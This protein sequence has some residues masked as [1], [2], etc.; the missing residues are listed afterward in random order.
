MSE[1]VMPPAIGVGVTEAEALTLTGS[2]SIEDRD[3]AS[4]GRN[5][6][7]ES[8]T[9]PGLASGV[10]SGPTGFY[11]IAVDFFNEDDGAS[12]I[13]ILVNGVVAGG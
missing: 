5:L 7:A 2:F 11:T 3:E 8:E 1:T 10:F 13:E 9:T 4:G 6:R 12:V